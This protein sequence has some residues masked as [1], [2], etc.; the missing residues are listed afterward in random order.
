MQA[1]PSWADAILAA[2]SRSEPSIARPSFAEPS[3]SKPKITHR[4]LESILRLRNVSLHISAK[5]LA[6]AMAYVTECLAAAAAVYIFAWS[7]FV[8]AAFAH[9]RIL[10]HVR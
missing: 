2:Q 9:Q 1:E 4:V 5:W 10:S 7:G 3:Q 6:P 8:D